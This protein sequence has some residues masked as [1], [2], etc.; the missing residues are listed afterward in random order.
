MAIVSK[1]RRLSNTES[2]KRIPQ[3]AGVYELGDRNRNIIYI[4]HAEGGNLQNRVKVHINDPFNEC[5][6]IRAIYFRCRAQK[7]HKSGEIELLRQYKAQ[8]NGNIPPCNIQDPS[9]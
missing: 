4:G 1:W 8:N 2:I 9:P 6:R 7:A 3:Q 5:I